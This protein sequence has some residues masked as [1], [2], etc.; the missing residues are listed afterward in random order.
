M[1][2]LGKYWEG[3]MPA[4]SDIYKSARSYQTQARGTGNPVLRDK[5]FTE[6]VKQY[7][8]GLSQI[9]YEAKAQKWKE[10]YDQQNLDI[11]R[12][13]LDLQKQ[14]AEMTSASEAE[15]TAMMKEVSD[16]EIELKRELAA[17]ELDYKRQYDEK[18]E[19]WKKKE[20]EW[21][22]KEWGQSQWGSMTNLGLGIAGMGVAGYQ[23]FKGSPQD[24]YWDT[25]YGREFGG[26]DLGS[27]TQINTGFGSPSGY[28]PQFKLEYGGGSDPFGAGNQEYGYSDPWVSE[29]EQFG[30]DWESDWD[31]DWGSGWDFGGDW[32]SDWGQYGDWGDWGSDWD[33]GGYDWD[34][35]SGDYGGFDTGGWGGDFDYG[36]YTWD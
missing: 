27:P 23:A 30:G 11:E 13:R 29:W 1:A 28:Q 10:Y 31:F 15:R 12:G 34:F 2:E 20:E 7:Y 22:K 26:R 8:G 33:S 19:E 14:I 16:R 6:L 21:K 35:S 24:K 36:G 25:R 3:Y 17:E 4:M 5:D 9:G 32:G 18:G